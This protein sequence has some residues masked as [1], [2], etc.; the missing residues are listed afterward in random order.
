M[1]S[2]PQYAGTTLAFDTS[3]GHCAAAVLRDGEIVIAKGEDMTRGQAERLVP[4]LE[5]VLA[6]AGLAWSDI[7]RIGVGV[8]PGN[9]TGIRIS[10]ATARGL[11]LGLGVPAI[12]VTT[13]D[14]IASI[15][16]G[17]TAVP[18]PR[19]QVYLSRAGHAPELVP[20]D[21]AGPATL[22]PPPPELAAAIARCAA[23][24]DP[25]ECPA[26]APFYLRPADAAPSRDLP[27]ALL[28]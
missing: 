8:G 13:F 2:A 15:T 12:G 7:D 19:D 6:E 9:F 16:P 24:A 3:A 1:T 18:A 23:A 5:E 28:D 22:P 20:K 21:L 11:A 26:P 27:P 4:L 25:T 10:V 17:D 14:A